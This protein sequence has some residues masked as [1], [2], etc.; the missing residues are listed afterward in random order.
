MALSAASSARPAHV[1]RVGSKPAVTLAGVPRWPVAEKT[2]LPMVLGSRRDARIRNGE[3]ILLDDQDRSRW[4]E[5]QMRNARRLLERALALLNDLDLDSSQYCHSTRA[6]FL[7]RLG[8]NDEA[9]AAYARALQLAQTEPEQRFL[10]SRLHELDTRGG[11]A[12]A[13]G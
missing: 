11:D 3:L 7:R 5:P 8:S 12:G 2:A 13:D 10:R 6:E 4:N 9:R 1:Q